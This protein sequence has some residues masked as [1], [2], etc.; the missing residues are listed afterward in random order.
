MIRIK[1][2]LDGGSYAGESGGLGGVGKRFNA[3][4]PSFEVKQ[5]EGFR[6][7]GLGFRVLGIRGLGFRVQG[8]RA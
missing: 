1:L 6:A 3:G 7:L 8:F 2:P 5:C 4:G